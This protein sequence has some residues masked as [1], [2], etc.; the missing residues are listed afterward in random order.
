MRGSQ[1]A[2]E[3]IGKKQFK[4]LEIPTAMMNVFF[5]LHIEISYL[6]LKKKKIQTKKPTPS[7][8]PAP[9]FGFT[10]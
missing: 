10:I 2:K 9:R 8:I 6:A 4:C 1:F 3:M 7:S 5:F